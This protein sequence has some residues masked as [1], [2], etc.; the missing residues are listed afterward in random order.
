MSDWM[1]QICRKLLFVANVTIS[2]WLILIISFTIYKAEGSLIYLLREGVQLK[3]DDFT[4][5]LATITGEPVYIR[6]Y[7]PYLSYPY[8]FA[9]VYEPVSFT[10]VCFSVFW[11][12][13]G[14]LLGYLSKTL[15]EIILSVIS[16]FTSILTF[17]LVLNYAFNIVSASLGMLLLLISALSSYHYKTK[18]LLRG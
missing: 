16:Q 15:N 2:M 10:I 6:V 5:F 1:K 8:N 4:R 13:N 12:L 9:D 7:M 18:V 14:I 3:I 11:I 17:F